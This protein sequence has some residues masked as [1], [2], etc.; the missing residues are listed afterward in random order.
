ME[1]R[2]L[3]SE[4]ARAGRFNG[5]RGWLSLL[6][7][8]LCCG[9][10]TTTIA[11]RARALPG[12]ANNEAALREAA[13]SAPQNYGN[14]S[15][16]S[17]GAHADFAS[18]ASCGNCHQRRGASLQPTLPGHKACIN[19]HLAQ[20]TN[21]NL[22]MCSICHTGDASGAN[23]PVKGFPGLRSFRTLFDH[24]QHVVKAGATCVRCHDPAQRGVAFSVPADMNAHRQCYE[25]HTFGLSAS[26]LSS[27][28]TCHAV[29]GFAISYPGA[30]AYGIGFSH[31]THGARQRLSCTDCHTIKA[32][33]APSKQVSSPA[34]FQHFP[35]SRAQSCATCHNNQ[36]AFGEADFGNC[37]KCHKGQT[38]RIGE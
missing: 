36:R 30:R 2:E 12:N 24:Q 11:L 22:A 13:F 37:R 4:D 26:N 34:S 20:F 9:A 18:A 3:K 31:A 8:V 1:K 7:L 6:L 17:P 19:C 29:G 27:C 15:H 5:V 23:P 25:C 33:G 32:G 21:A 28:G 38:F 35:Q 14:F 10:V 16:T